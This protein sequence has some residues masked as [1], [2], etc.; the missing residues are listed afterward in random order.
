MKP[1]SSW[2]WV[3]AT[4]LVELLAQIEENGAGHFLLPMSQHW[5]QFPQKYNTKEHSNAQ[6][7]YPR[8]TSCPEF[9][10]SFFMGWWTGPLPIK[11][12]S[13]TLFPKT[14]PLSQI[15]VPSSL[16]PSD[17]PFLSGSTQAPLPLW[18]KGSHR[19]PLKGGSESQLRPHQPRARFP[20]P[21]YLKVVFSCKA[22]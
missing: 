21:Y 18:V 14:L 13:F 11:K 5:A 9:Q 1:C 4:Y 16:T 17:L 15:Q 12:P 6:S 2:K 20:S 10:W 19:P 7:L 3:S 8:K 22:N